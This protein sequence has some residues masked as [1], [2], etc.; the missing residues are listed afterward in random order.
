MTK[1]E[2]VAV[3]ILEL[4]GVSG[5]CSCGTVARCPNRGECCGVGS[6]EQREIC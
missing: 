4:P 5:G 6:V 2:F 1:K 3:R